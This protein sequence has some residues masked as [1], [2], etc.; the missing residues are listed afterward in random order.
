M[1]VCYNSLG[2]ESA[3]NEHRDLGL[4]MLI[5]LSDDNTPPLPPFQE[6]V[7]IPLGNMME[8]YGVCMNVSTKRHTKKKKKSAIFSAYMRVSG[9]TFHAYASMQTFNWL[10]SIPP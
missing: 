2:R 7:S 6:W 4:L 1:S 8:F 9:Q 5:G 10:H 3:G